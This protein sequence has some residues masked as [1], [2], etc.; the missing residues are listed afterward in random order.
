MCYFRGIYMHK[1]SEIEIEVLPANEGDCILIKAVKE[2]IHI[3]IDGGTA[4]TYR[5][6]LRARLNQL[7]NEGKKIDL[8]I[9][10]HIDNDHIGG[11]IE[12]LKENGTNTN[13]K[14]IRIDNIWHNSYRH[15]QIKKKQVL[16]KAEKNILDKII[17]NGEVSLNYSSGN[18]SAISARQ[19][20]TLAGLIFQG[21]YHWNEQFDEQ[22]VM[23]NGI[24]Y[25]FGK[26]CFVTVLKPNI[27]D[28][29]RLG[30]KWKR[31]LKKSKYSFVFSEDK[32]FDDAFEYYFRCMPTD[33]KGNYE[34]IS[35]S[36]QNIQEKTIEEI[37]GEPVSID[38]SVTNR[39]SISIII[40]YKNRK[41]LF[42]ADNIADGILEYISPEDRAFSLVKLPHHGS[43][44]NISNKFIEC[45]ESD[46]YVVSTSSEKYDH[47]DIET[48]AKIACKGTE[49]VKRIYFNY[50]IDKVAEFEKKIYGMN[51]IEFVYLGEG[52]K[53]YL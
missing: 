44:N 32:I 1:E 18:N 11:I 16:G 9:V 8:L 46:T 15:L 49:Y 36:N 2:D 28:L 47:P 22:A 3:L 21:G 31:D 50:K 26:E 34:K 52:Q 5:N 29:E 13:P 40:K 53:I 43:V 51:D 20:T 39:S 48:L 30:N 24:Y 4:E 37:S 38:N 6:Y 14:I 10:T 33:V 19:G 45:I 23:N 35:Y 7:R 25:Q 41:L 42:L 17:Y 27:S 12:L